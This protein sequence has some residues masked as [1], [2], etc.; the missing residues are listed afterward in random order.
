MHKLLHSPLVNLD[1]TNQGS[2]GSQ[3]PLK[4]KRGESESE[5]CFFLLF[6]HFFLLKL[7]IQKL[8]EKKT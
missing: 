4:R 5:G 3:A 8:E 6:S 7:V 1:E 2:E